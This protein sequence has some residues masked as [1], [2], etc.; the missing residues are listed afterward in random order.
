M[1]CFV[2]YPLLLDFCYTN[3]STLRDKWSLAVA[4]H[5]YIGVFVFQP[6]G[7]GAAESFDQVEYSFWPL[8]LVQAY[9]VNGGGTDERLLDLIANSHFG[10][11]VLVV[12]DEY[13]DDMRKHAVHLHKITPVGWF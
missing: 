10:D 2:T 12:I 5:E 1:E 3:Y 7:Y 11:E 13:V 8:P 4:E 6:E 9:L